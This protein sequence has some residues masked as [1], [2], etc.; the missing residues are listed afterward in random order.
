M[1]YWAVRVGERRTAE[2]V[3]RVINRDPP[4]VDEVSAIATVEQA[5]T[6]RSFYSIV[7]QQDFFSVDLLGVACR[8]DMTDNGSG[9]LELVFAAAWYSWRPGRSARGPTA[10]WGP[11]EG[12][13]RF[14]QTVLRE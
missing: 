1:E 5:G 6:H 4:A 9:Y 2:L 8:R 11:R 14:I 12:G 13:A 10:A 7:A 3:L